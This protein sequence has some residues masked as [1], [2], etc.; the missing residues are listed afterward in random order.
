MRKCEPAKVSTIPERCQENMPAHPGLRW[1]SFLLQNLAV[2]WGEIEPGKNPM[3]GVSKFRD[4]PSRTLLSEHGG[5]QAFPGG[6]GGGAQPAVGLRPAAAAVHRLP[7][8]GGAQAQMGGRVHRRPDHGLGRDQERQV[9]GG[10]PQPAEPGRDRETQGL[11]QDRQSVPVPGEFGG[12]SPANRAPDLRPCAEAGGAGGNGCGH[13]Y[14]ATHPRQPAGQPGRIAG[15]DQGQSG[16]QFGE[17]DGEVRPHRRRQEQGRLGPFGRT[18][19][20]GDESV[21]KWCSLAF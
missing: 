16:A 13:P 14:P 19:A 17:D 5:V 10:L 7:R 20:G 8:R 3:P 12:W 11:A 21:R 4:N 18:A 1:T 15:D 6:F 2:K 9:A